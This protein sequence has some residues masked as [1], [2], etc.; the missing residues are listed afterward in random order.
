MV[1]WRYL[2]GKKHI[3]HYVRQIKMIIPF[4]S[5]FLCGHLEACVF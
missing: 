2:V 1:G 3:R 4:Q 5:Y